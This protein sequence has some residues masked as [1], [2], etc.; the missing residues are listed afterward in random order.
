MSGTRW[1]APSASSTPWD[2][3]PDSGLTP[4]QL[5]VRDGH[6]SVYDFRHRPL[7]E[8]GDAAFF[9]GYERDRCPRC[10]GGRIQRWG[11]EAGGVRRWRCASCGRTFT[12]ATGTIFE[13]R[14]LPV[15]DWVEFLGQAFGFESLE[16]MTREDRRSGTT[17]AWWMTKLFAVL[18]G[19]QDGVVLSGEVQVDEKMHP[20]AARDRAGGRAG[21]GAYSRDRI[22]IAVGCDD[23]GRSLMVGA[24]LGKLSKARCW[25]AYGGHINTGRDSRAR[26]GEQPLGARRA[27][28]AGERRLQVRRPEGA[29]R[30][31]QPALASQPHALL[32]EGVHAPALR[33]REGPRRR[34]AQ[35]LLGHRQPARGP[36]GE[37]S[38]GPRQGNGRP[39]LAALQGVLRTGPQVREV[40]AQR[41]ANFLQEGILANKSNQ[42]DLT[43]KLLHNV[44]IAA[45]FNLQS[46]SKKEIGGLISA[47]DNDLARFSLR[48][49]AANFDRLVDE[50]FDRWSPSG[51]ISI[52]A[53]DT[54]LINGQISI[55]VSLLSGNV[56]ACRN[57]L[58]N[59]A[60]IGLSD[61]WAKG[62]DLVASLLMLLR[63]GDV[64]RLGQA[65]DKTK[66]TYDSKDTI[67]FVEALSPDGVTPI[68][69]FA[70]MK[71]V[72]ACGEYLSRSQASKWFTF[73]ISVV[74]NPDNFAKRYTVPGTYHTWQVEAVRCICSMRYQLT[75]GELKQAFE[76]ILT[77][78]LSLESASSEIRRLIIAFNED[79][80]HSKE[81]IAIGEDA[82][83][84]LSSIIDEAS[85]VNTQEER[86]TI[87]QEILSG[88]LSCV[89]KIGS[90]DNL[91]LDEIEAIANQGLAVLKEIRIQADNGMYG[92]RAIDYGSL[93]THLLV[94]YLADSGCWWDEI[95]EFLEKPLIE[96]REKIS[97]AS[98]ITE[99]IMRVP[100][101]LARKI[102]DHAS[103]IM[104]SMERSIFAQGNG[105]ERIVLKAMLTAVHGRVYGFNNA[106]WMGACDSAGINKYNVSLLAYANNPELTLLTVC[107]SDDFELR[108]KA[109]EVLVS[110]CCEDE[111]RYNEYSDFF[112][113][114]CLCGCSDYARGFINALYEKQHYVTGAKG[115][116][117]NL[118]EKH[119]SGIVRHYAA[120]RLSM[121]W[122]QTTPDT[123]N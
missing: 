117:I 115:L 90:I 11:H 22:C 83:K 62:D 23:S 81:D 36:P 14:K 112:S 91:R 123:A 6:R 84:W 50:R 111:Q 57:E 56:P 59:M 2:G 16:A 39:G 18:E 108:Y 40:A 87:H 69:A 21:M 55:D 60:M 110:V 79:G 49:D 5:A 75:I 58:S 51:R 3:V 122:E 88:N 102:D 41:D 72:Q 20:L 43:A 78:K 105:D 118:K 89:G 109:F 61:R 94:H 47:R 32:P 4:A 95:I 34:L 66:R 8:T 67:R 76:S 52:G 97:V 48:R 99:G 24:G 7:S 93:T 31:P 106:L 119:P 82:P 113:N 13:D 53:S 1:H 70:Y 103:E 74:G 26:H 46:S 80:D 63:A 30:R 101:E 96:N 42:T 12:P 54:I 107:S 77:S 15:A 120:E 116:L 65:L 25:D 86:E 17:V 27:A 35:P 121:Q 64:N 100:V 9:N 45:S 85:P 28:R 44:A 71:A 37:G 29:G 104:R 19:V 33:L 98:E 38:D 73:L 10:G 68:T 114:R 92:A